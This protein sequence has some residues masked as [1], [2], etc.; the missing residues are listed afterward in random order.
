MDA[1]DTEKWLYLFQILY[2]F[3]TSPKTVQIM[4]GEYSYIYITAP[5]V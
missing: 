5:E 2:K 4:P 3:C 1:L